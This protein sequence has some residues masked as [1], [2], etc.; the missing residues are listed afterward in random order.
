MIFSRKYWCFDRYWYSFAC[1]HICVLVKLTKYLGKVKKCKAAAVSSPPDLWPVFCP[2]DTVTPLQDFLLHVIF[3]I[4]IT[5]SK[6]T[7]KQI[8]TDPHLKA[9]KY[10]WSAKKRKMFQLKGS[11]IQV[12]ILCQT[13]SWQW[14]D[15]KI[16]SLQLFRSHHIGRWIAWAHWWPNLAGMI[17]A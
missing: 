10:S 16:S 2:E 14:T 4:I 6:Q 1:R 17:M 8:S 12:L 3:C 11:L 13:K 9:K 7:N 5:E 15:L